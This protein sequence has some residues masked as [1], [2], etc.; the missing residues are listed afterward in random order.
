MLHKFVVSRPLHKNVGGTILGTV[1]KLHAAST[2]YA[3][4]ICRYKQGGNSLKLSLAGAPLASTN[5]GI[6]SGSS[7]IVLVELRRL[8]SL[9]E[10]DY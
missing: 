6:E 7:Y 8:H 9:L 10:W 2:S 5:T 3:I 4:Y 1:K